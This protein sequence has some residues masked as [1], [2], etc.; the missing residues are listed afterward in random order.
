MKRSILGGKNLMSEIK[1]DQSLKQLEKLVEEMEEEE[2][3]LE[4]S[5]RKYE[6]GIGLA[7][8][9]L[10]KLNQAE[11]RIE[12][13]KKPAGASPETRPLEVDLG[14]DNEEMDREETLRE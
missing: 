6:E 2:M 11:K 10:E 8:S 4:K 3:P 13:L 7:R 1:F 12:I 14:P 5:L 9:C